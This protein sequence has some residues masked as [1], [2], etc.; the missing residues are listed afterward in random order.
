MSPPHI[1]LQNEPNLI[2][3]VGGVDKLTVIDSGPA[4]L[5]VSISILGN[6][7]G[8]GG[9]GVF[10]G[11]TGFTVMLGGV[12]VIGD[13]LIFFGFTE[14]PNSIEAIGSWVLLLLAKP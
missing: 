7:G 12:T 4:G 14:A 1:A 10:K 6:C 3:K 2:L 9:S 11:V 13:L 5:N 8:S